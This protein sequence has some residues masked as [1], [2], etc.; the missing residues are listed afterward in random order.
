MTFKFQGLTG[1]PVSGKRHLTNINLPA[2]AGTNFFRLLCS[3]APHLLLEAQDCPGL[4][5]EVCPAFAGGVPAAQL[6]D[7]VVGI[8]CQPRRDLP[9]HDHPWVLS[10]ACWLP[11][12]LKASMPSQA[13]PGKR[14]SWSCCS[15]SPQIYLRFFNV[16][17]RAWTALPQRASPAGSWLL[18]SISVQLFYPSCSSS[19]SFGEGKPDS[20]SVKPS[21]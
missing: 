5:H 20:H 11:L 8:L 18:F 14:G 12:A 2:T 19:T 21:F 3:S 15:L 7:P 6:Q 9:G 4:V 1:I 13:S 17:L 10:T 16:L